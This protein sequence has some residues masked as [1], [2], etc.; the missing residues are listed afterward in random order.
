[1]FPIPLK[2]ESARRATVG[3]A[4]LVAVAS[5]IAGCGTDS[6]GDSANGGD[7]TTIV[8]TYSVLGSLV[9]DAVGDNADVDYAPWDGNAGAAAPEGISD[10]AQQQTDRA[11]L[12][13]RRAVL[14][15]HGLDPED[16]RD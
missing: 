16:P 12:A 2:C 8:V 1:M 5:V 3:L 10:A 15:L 6:S 7:R 14:P 9:S 11:I 13:A 4:A